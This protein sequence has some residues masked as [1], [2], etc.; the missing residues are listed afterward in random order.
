MR[1]CALACTRWKRRRLLF[2][3]IK[4]ITMEA[5]TLMRVAE[6][7]FVAVLTIAVQPS[8]QSQTYT[9]IDPPGSEGTTLSS[10]NPAGAIT[11]FFLDANF[12]PHGFLR[13]P[14]G[15]I[16]PF[17]PPSSTGTTPEAINPGGVITGYY[18]TGDYADENLVSHGFLRA[19]DGTITTFDAP[20]AGTGF[21]QGTTVYAI[22]PA[23]AITGYYTD[24][25]SVSHG[26]VRTVTGTFTSFDVPGSAGTV[27]D[28]INPTGVVTGYYMAPLG[29]GFS[30]PVG[31]VRDAK[32]AITIIAPEGDFTYLVDDYPSSINLAGT[33]AGTASNINVNASGF[34]LRAKDGSITWFDNLPGLGSALGININLGGT[35]TGDYIDWDSGQIL[36]FVRTADGQVSLIADPN[37]GTGFFQGTEA[38]LINP[39]G[40]IAGNYSD[41]NYV[42][43]GF[44]RTP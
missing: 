9:T 22:N 34:Y 44:L 42:S 20:G 11:G 3:L 41:E 30:I 4:E 29:G 33:I 15:A 16:T 23:G 32:G 6:T 39:A 36:S 40:Q 27:A 28:A 18:T 10:I 31:F 43:H 5:T 17:D 13:T 38:Y 7:T 37:A 24:A 14:N 35:A 21:F 26:F 19:P 25:N 8:A 2:P 1:Y 12:V